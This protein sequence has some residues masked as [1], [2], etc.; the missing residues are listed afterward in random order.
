VQAVSYGPVVLAG[1]YG[2]DAST[3]MPRLDTASLK[4]S[5]TQPQTFTATADGKPVTLSPIA[6]MHHRHYNVY[7]QT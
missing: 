7:W 6:R 5:S 3:A 2:S 1:G 4:P